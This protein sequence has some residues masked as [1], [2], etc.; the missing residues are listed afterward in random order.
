MQC[1][2]LFTEIRW[3]TT[4]LLGSTQDGLKTHLTMQTEECVCDPITL[5]REAQLLHLFTG[6]GNELRSPSDL[7]TLLKT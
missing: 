2:K 7:A 1:T 6:V 5:H 3:E 4:T